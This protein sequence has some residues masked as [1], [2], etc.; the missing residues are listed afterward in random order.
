MKMNI[1]VCVKQVPDTVDVKINKETNTLAREGVDSVVNPFDLCAIEA[2]LRLT[3]KYG[4]TVMVLSMGPP[5]AID[6]LQEAISM[7]VGDAV[8]LSDIAFAGSDT[9][10]TSY[11]LAKGIEKVGRFDLI[12]CGRQAIDG[13]T[14]QVGPE[15]AERLNVPHLS[16][17][18][19]IH[20]VS[21]GNMIA[22]RMMEDGVE[23]MKISLP[24]LITVAKGINEPRLPS[25]KGKIRAIRSS[26]PVWSA[27]DIA[28]DPERVGLSGSPT[29]VKKIFVPERRSGGVLLEGSAE[30]Q[31]ASLLRNLR[32][33]DVLMEGSMV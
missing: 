3:E 10:A 23:K 17:V 21:G 2:G 29:R 7:G 27:D 1:I 24:V 9:L 31:A 20:E 32:E 26:I 5:Q 6:V 28:A 22:D 13:D 16:C 4:G 18:V 25:L 11:V 8:L 19:T 15:L 33:A 30:E 12:I 14:A